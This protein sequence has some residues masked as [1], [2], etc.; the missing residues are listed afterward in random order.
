MPTPRQPE[1]QISEARVDRE[2]EIR[3]N[4]PNSRARAFRNHCGG[5]WHGKGTRITRQNVSEQRA[6]LRPGDVVIRGGRFLTSGLEPGSA[7]RI[8]WVSE[9]VA[10]EMVGTVVARFLSVEVKRPK[11]A[12]E[13]ALQRN[14]A[15]R[16]NRAG[17]RAG[18][19]RSADEAAEIAWGNR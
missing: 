16:V 3:I 13:Q 18:F 1:P 10:P 5:S 12:R 6:L 19:A 8:G 2:I 15:D 17:G 7:D 4:A 9:V 11:N 14:W